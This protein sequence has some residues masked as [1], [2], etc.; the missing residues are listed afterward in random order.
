[1]NNTILESSQNNEINYNTLIS[2]FSAVGGILTIITGYLLKAHIQHSSCWNGK[3]CDISCID[4]EER[5]EIEKTLKRVRTQKQRKKS[6]TIE[7]KE[8]TIV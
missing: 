7:M 5:E 8:V 4:R 6:E 3:C 2:V 1:M